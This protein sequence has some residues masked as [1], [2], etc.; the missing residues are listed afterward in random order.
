MD[1]H[2]ITIAIDGHASA[3]KSTM[4]RALAAELGCVYVDPGAMYRAAALFAMRERAI[5]PEGL[6]AEQLVQALDRLFIQFK[7]NPSTG[8]QETYLSGINVE[9][10]I[11]SAEVSRWVSPVATVPA[12]RK[13]LVHLQRRMAAMGGVVMDGRDIGTVVLPQAD[14]KFFVTAS[15]EVRAQRRLAE[16]RAAGRDDTFESILANVLERDRIDSTREVAPLVQAPDA[17]VLD[18]SHLTLDEQ[19]EFLL[20]HARR[21]THPA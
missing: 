9:K 20:S 15:P 19:F 13:K 2:R 12:L 11:R 6:D 16:L 7:Y 14:L 1:R 5:G 10:E 21:I 4:A 17:I 18:N 3:G 8:R